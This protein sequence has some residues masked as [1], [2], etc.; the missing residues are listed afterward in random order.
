MVMWGKK[1]YFT[2]R[3]KSATGDGTFQIKI[4]ADLIECVSVAAERRN[5]TLTSI[6]MQ[7]DEDTLINS[8]WHSEAQI[9]GLRV[10]TSGSH[11]V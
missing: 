4:P 9:Q 6:I 7:R 3:H 11:Q 1:G 2:D 10:H 5:K 8:H